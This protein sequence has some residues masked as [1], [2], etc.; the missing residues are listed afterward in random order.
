MK[1]GEKR[2]EVATMMLGVYFGDFHDNSIQSFD[3]PTCNGKQ[4]IKLPICFIGKSTS[5]GL[6]STVM[7]D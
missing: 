6:Y 4:Q 1:D 2:V 5:N 7:L 3:L